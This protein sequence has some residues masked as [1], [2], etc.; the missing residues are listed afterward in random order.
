MTFRRPRV[1]DASALVELFHG[2]PKMMRLLDDAGAGHFNLAIP[3]VA[4]AEAQAV[5]AVSA[6]VWDHVMTYPGVTELP[7]CTHAAIDTGNLARPRL[8]H[9]PVHK[10]LIGPLM[11]GQVVREAVTMNGI[12][13]TRVPE[14]YGG[15]D[16]AVKAF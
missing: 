1:L 7:L 10:S 3:T 5:L 8:E 2:H 12:V 9:H 16:V 13:Y 4:I 6:S 15:Q 14:A 11:V